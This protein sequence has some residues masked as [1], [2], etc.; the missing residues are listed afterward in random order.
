MARGDVGDKVSSGERLSWLLV[1]ALCLFFGYRLGAQSG[2]RERSELRRALELSTS[3]AT[4]RSPSLRGSSH[5][6]ETE[7]TEEREE[8]QAEVGEAE[9]DER[10]AEVVVATSLTARVSLSEA[11]RARLCPPC[12]CPCATPKPKPVKSRARRLPPPKMT[13]LERAKL[14]AWVRRHS[15]RLRRCRDTGQPIYRLHSRLRL[16]ADASGVRSV[17]LK[18]KQVPSSALSCIRSEMLKWPPPEGLTPAKHPLLIFNLQ[19]D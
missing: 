13:P 12:E 5:D 17:Q 7:E 6:E 3:D 15:E 4:A 14:L 19:L 18:G 8:N 2:A 11:E 10:E 16:K 9:V 1:V